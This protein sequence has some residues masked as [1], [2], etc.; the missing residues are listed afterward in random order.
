MDFKTVTGNLLTAFETEGIRYALIGGFAMGVWGIARST[1]DMDF[2]IHKSDLPAVNR[3]LTD[4]GYE[5]GYRT[6]NVSQYVSPLHIFGEI[7]ILHAFREIS[8]GM[9]QRAESRK[10]FG[11]SMTLK[12]LKIEDLIGLKVQ[13]IANDPARKALDL[14]DIESLMKLYGGKINW[15]FIKEYFALFDL[16]DLFR[17]LW[18]RYGE[19]E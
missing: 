18:N 16:D 14:A 7:D 10:I 6:E 4:M 3:I 12:V 8:L 2:L 9:L 15:P 17:Q 19:T 1:V 11:E 5:C 13:A